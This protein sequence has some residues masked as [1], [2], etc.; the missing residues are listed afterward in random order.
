M[1]TYDGT[2]RVLDPETGEQ[3]RAIRVIAPWREKADW[4]QPGPAVEVT[5][6][7]AYVT[8]AANKEL[9]VVD[10]AAGTVVRRVDLPH[11][12]MELTVVDGHPEAPAHEHAHD[13]AH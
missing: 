13:H 6:D 9:V 5:G 10:V 3:T 7:L 11:V 4:Q 2:L 12:P 1:L 8:D